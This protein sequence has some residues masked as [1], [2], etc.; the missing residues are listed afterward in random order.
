MTMP[1]IKLHFSLAREDSFELKPRVF[2]FGRPRIEIRIR[3]RPGSAFWPATDQ[4]SVPKIF[5][6]PTGQTTSDIKPQHQ[7]IV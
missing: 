2:I 4:R 7:K 3:R 6:I 1:K 5:F